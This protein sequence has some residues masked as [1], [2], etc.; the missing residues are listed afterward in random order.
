[1]SRI[2]DLAREVSA[3]IFFVAFALLM[4][5]PHF[6][7]RWGVPIA[8]RDYAHKGDEDNRLDSIIYYYK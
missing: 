8:T 1:M 4:E 6:G 5:H 2:V 7:T 3:R